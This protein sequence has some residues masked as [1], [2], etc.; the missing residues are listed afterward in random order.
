M[1]AQGFGG[2]DKVKGVGDGMADETEMEEGSAYQVSVTFLPNGK[3][4][5]SE[6]TPMPMGEGDEEMD[7][8][9]YGKLFMNADKAIRYVME[10][11]DGMNGDE[12]IM[13]ESFAGKPKKKVAAS[14]SMVPEEELAG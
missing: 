10:Q 2:D 9:S 14:V 1:D 5:V 6:M 3:V 8:H 11:V 7:E 13:A 12:E 4:A